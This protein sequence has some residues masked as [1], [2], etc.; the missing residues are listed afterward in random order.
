MNGVL[1][2]ELGLLTALEGVDFGR[3]EFSGTLPTEIGRLANL[4]VL[5]VYRNEMTG[6]IPSQLG[7]LTALGML[8]CPIFCRLWR[9]TT[10]LCFSVLLAHTL[11]SHAWLSLHL[12][13]STTSFW[14]CWQQ[15]QQQQQHESRAPCSG[16][17]FI[18]WFHPCNTM[19]GTF[20]NLTWLHCGMRV[21]FWGM[22][23]R[24]GGIVGHWCRPPSNLLRS[25]Q[26]LRRCCTKHLKVHITT[27]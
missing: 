19:R 22:R 21:L 13:C 10:W 27:V 17:E 20:W 7:E 16:I 5:S 9:T 12:Y 24:L 4:S 2:T 15:Q 8:P 14:I 18:Q 23:L 3:S 25:L 11:V 6:T 1:P 26:Q